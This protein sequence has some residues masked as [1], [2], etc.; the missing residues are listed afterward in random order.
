MKCD[1]CAVVSLL[2]LFDRV[3]VRAGGFPL[4]SFV[5]AVSLADY[6]YFVTDHERRIEPYTELTDDI[7][8]IFL[9]HCCLEI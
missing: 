9:V 7:D 6:G 4:I 5:G 2:R 8:F 3:T 1:L